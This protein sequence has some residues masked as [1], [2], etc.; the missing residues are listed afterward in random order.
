MCGKGFLIGFAN[1]AI[2]PSPLDRAMEYCVCTE[3]EGRLD[4]SLCSTAKKALQWANLNFLHV[5]TATGY[6]ENTW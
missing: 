2:P 4:D 6:D 5:P 3:I 1:H